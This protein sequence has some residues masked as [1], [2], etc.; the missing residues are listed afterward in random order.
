MN[1]HAETR[2]WTL[3]NSHYHGSF[4]PPFFPMKITALLVLTTAVVGAQVQGLDLVGTVLLLVAGGAAWGDL[5]R[6]VKALE[7]EVRRLRDTSPPGGV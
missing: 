3:H 6:R 5:S 1:E 7:D 2:P 4:P